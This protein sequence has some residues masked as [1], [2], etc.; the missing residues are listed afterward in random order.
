MR[1]N[2]GNG[3]VPSF[4]TRTHT[5]LKVFSSV[6]IVL[7]LHLFPHSHFSLLCHQQDHAI[8]Q[9]LNKKKKEKAFSIGLH[10]FQACFACIVSC[11]LCVCLSKHVNGNKHD[12]KLGILYKI[13][14]GRK[15]IEDIFLHIPLSIMV[16]MVKKMLK[17]YGVLEECV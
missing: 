1:R 3:D 11:V 14:A 4:S 5:P 6:V 13:Q 12:E 2:D 8:I 17:F 15:R 9:Q 16:R 7:L 10:N